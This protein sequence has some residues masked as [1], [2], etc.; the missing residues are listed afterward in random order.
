MQV[1]TA[2]EV[3]KH[4]S[5]ESAWIIIRK[6]VYD[7]TEFLNE[8]P[9]GDLLLLDR[10]GNDATIEFDGQEHSADAKEILKEKLIG[11]LKIE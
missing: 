11:R 8:H 3:A 2:E 4:N 7:V 6:K 1:F 5:R 9:G 10:A